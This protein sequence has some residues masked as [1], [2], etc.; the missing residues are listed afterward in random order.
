[1]NPRASTVSVANVR[2]GSA[3]PAFITSAVVP[4]AA[5]VVATTMTVVD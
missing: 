2:L 5:D 4:A 1:M 3:G